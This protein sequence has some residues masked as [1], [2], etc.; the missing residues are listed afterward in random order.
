MLL[1]RGLVHEVP[2]VYLCGTIPLFIGVALFAYT[3][4]FAPERAA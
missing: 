1:L 3:L 4:W 2:P